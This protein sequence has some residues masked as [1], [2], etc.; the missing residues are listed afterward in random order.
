MGAQHT[1]THLA[2]FWLYLIF[3]IHRE[4]AVLFK[5]VHFSP[6]DSYGVDLKVWGLL[7]LYLLSVIFQP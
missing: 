4:L 3:R 2:C 6:A 7:F 5:S 1:G